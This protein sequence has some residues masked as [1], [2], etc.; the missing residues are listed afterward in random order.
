[1]RIERTQLEVAAQRG[2]INETQVGALWDF[3]EAERA[4]G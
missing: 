3:F 2:I 4:G 1:M